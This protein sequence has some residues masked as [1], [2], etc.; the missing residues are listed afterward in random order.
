MSVSRFNFAGFSL[1]RSADTSTHEVEIGTVTMGE[2]SFIVHMIRKAGL[3]FEGSFLLASIYDSAGTVELWNFKAAGREGLG[4]LARAGDELV[5]AFVGNGKAGEVND[6]MSFASIVDHKP[7]SLERKLELKRAAADFLGR[8]YS[9]S[10]VED[11]LH[12][13]MLA[14]KREDEAAAKGTITAYTAD[15]QKRYGYPVVGDEWQSLSKN[16][17]VVLCESYDQAARQHGKVIE[18]FRVVKEKGQNPSKGNSALVTLEQPKLAIFASSE[19]PKPVDTIAVLTDDGSFEVAVYATMD[20]IRAARASG[21]NSGSF[22]A[23]LNRRKDDGRYEVLSVR[24]DAVST[25]GL[26]EAL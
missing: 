19:L 9:L 8:K 26:F 16:T 10:K 4:M 20:D 13:R 24:K 15:G 23:A 17:F 18:A 12:Q 3:S 21:L 11:A 14:K 1:V 25:I 6:V 7:I 22:V 2:S 5:I